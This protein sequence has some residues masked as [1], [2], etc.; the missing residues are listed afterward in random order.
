MLNVTE[1]SVLEG[2]QDLII[3]NK[4]ILQI[5]LFEKRKK[6]IEDYLKLRNF[7]K[8]KVIQRDHYFA[9]F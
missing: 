1:L 3:K 6:N 9:N 5:E 7:K 8:I 2:I 4:T